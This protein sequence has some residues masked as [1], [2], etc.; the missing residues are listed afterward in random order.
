MDNLPLRPCPVI[1]HLVDFRRDGRP[2]ISL[3][4][5]SCRAVD[6]QIVPQ[7]AE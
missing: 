6:A 2:H 1:A 7:S 4:L 5:I 3:E